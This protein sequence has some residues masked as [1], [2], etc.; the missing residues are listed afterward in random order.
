MQNKITMVTFFICIAALILG[1]VVYGK[2]VERKF[3]ADS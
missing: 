1:Y 2:F 3:G